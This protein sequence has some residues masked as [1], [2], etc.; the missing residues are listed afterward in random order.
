MKTEEP[1]FT[2]PRKLREQAEKKL[3]QKREKVL[4]DITDEA[5]AQ[6]LLHELQVHQIE[7]EMQNE[8]LLRAYEAAEAALKRYTIVFDQAPMGFITLEDD[9]TIAEMNFA[10]AEMIGD[11]RFSLMG[12]NFKLYLSN[13][14]RTAFSDFFNRAYTTHQKEAC[15]IMLGND[16]ESNRKIYIEGIVIEND[17]NCMLSLVDVTSF[18]E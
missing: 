1:D 10:A 12:S 6:K 17:K 9:G 7:L 13:E 16:I 15:K 8:E 14:S 2:D 18:T 3:Q 11:R 5:D 4:Q